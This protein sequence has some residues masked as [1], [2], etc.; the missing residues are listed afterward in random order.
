MTS[1]R[2]H[3][4]GGIDERG[5][6]TWRLRYRLDGRRF[7]KTVR[8]TKAQAQ[9]AL[10]DMLHSG[11]TGAHVAPAK[12]T[13][14]KWIDHWIAIGAPGN[15]RR[16]EVGERTIERYEEL[17]RCHVTPTLGHRPLQQLQ[18]SEIDD[19]YAKLENKISARTAHHV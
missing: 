6:N 15:K 13:L 5:E 8:G 19:L 10:R 14:T 12:L 9:K 4:D 2:G 1:K 7:T 16:R 18:S 17:L 11:D 3:G